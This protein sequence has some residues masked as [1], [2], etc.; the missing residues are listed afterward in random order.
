MAEVYLSEIFSSI[1]GEGPHVGCSAL[2]IRF[3]GCNL[4][5]GYC[6]TDYARE[7]APSFK[8]FKVPKT[9]GGA[10]TG[11]S[12]EREVPNPVSCAEVLRMISENP[13]LPDTVVITG[14]EPLL[15]EEAL[16][17]LAGELR[18]R[19]CSVHLE[20]K[21]TLPGSLESVKRAVDFVSMDIKLPS[22]LGG[23]D[24]SE[25]HAEFLKA[26]EGL[27]GC[28]KIVVSESVGE[29]EMD[30]AAGLIAGVNPGLPVYI[31]PVFT[32]SRPGI[33]AAGLGRLQARL[34]ARLHTVRVSVQIHKILGVR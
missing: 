19:G 16:G 33:G 22:M 13:D 27:E 5:C 12:C 29:R 10:A 20:T 18:L 32:G 17:Q 24:L 21:G 8:I 3:G 6:D 34:A 30:R 9:S 15:Q 14:G 31:Q 1:Q 7:R 25:R 2:F 26:M 23:T 4:S 11:A 28:V